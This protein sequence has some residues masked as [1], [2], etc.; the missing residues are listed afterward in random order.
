[1]ISDLK[2]SPKTVIAKCFHFFDIPSGS[3]TKMRS[4][5]QKVGKFKDFL[6]FL[7]FETFKCI[8]KALP[9]GISKKG[10]H[11]VI[12]VFCDLFKSGIR[13]KDFLTFNFAI[14]KGF[15]KFHLPVL[16]RGLM[17]ECSKFGKMILWWSFVGI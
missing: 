17:S 3:D 5:V 2:I 8:F 15:A 14:L 4:K 10:K 7:I 16:V 13:I 9:K 12:A 1:M 6:N 11:F